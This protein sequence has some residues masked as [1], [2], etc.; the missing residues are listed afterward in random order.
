[1]AVL[2]ATNYKGSQA[3][4][5]HDHRGGVHYTEQSSLGSGYKIY[6]ISSDYGGVSQR[7]LVVQSETLEAASLKKLLKKLKRL[8]EELGKKLAKLKRKRFSCQADA[9]KA[10]GSFGEGLT[11][12]RRLSD[13][14][15][16]SV[17]SPG[18]AG[19]PSS[20]GESGSSSSSGVCYRI[21]ARLLEEEAKVS[22]ARR[23]AGR[24]IL[25]TNVLD[26]EQLSNEALLAEYKA[27]DQVERGFRFLKDPL[28]FFTSSVFVKNPKQVAAIAMVMSLCLLVYALGEEL[29]RSLSG[30]GGRCAPPE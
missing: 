6:E 28:L 5:E 23:E 11:Y 3:D 17:N 12:H 10:A 13:L 18:K 20:K 19:R 8:E 4:S 24:F 2:G 25:A 1:M 16:V 29:T 14:R 9:R 22:S 21:E 26:D 30:G 15:I 27:K 7:W